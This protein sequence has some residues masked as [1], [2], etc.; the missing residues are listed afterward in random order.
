[1]LDWAEAGR[2]FWQME[3]NWIHQF[4]NLNSLEPEVR[5]TLENAV[6]IIEVPAGHVVFR[7]GDECQNYLLMLDGR[8]KVQMT[9]ETGREIILYR[10]ESGQSC[11][12]TTSCLLAHELYN[13]E[14]M[15]ETP[16]RAIAIPAHMFRDLI[17]RSE[18]LRDFV[19][20]TYGN[21]IADLMMVVEEVAFKRL[22]IRL[23]RL[24]TE[25]GKEDDRVITQTHQQIA[26]ELGSAREVISRQLK[27]FERRGWIALQRGKI[28]ILNLSALE[29]LSVTT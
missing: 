13:A 22:D 19:F 20:K 2:Y 10:V 17:G 28:E 29:A 5:Q 12:L 21:R 3:I 16:C 14:A 9:A 25:C 24:L 27:D 15:T 4:P 26:T 23:A 7:P 8:L 1:M 11:V 6:E 18:V